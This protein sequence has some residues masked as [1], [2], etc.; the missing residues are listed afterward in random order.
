[1]QT[2]TSH[3][4]NTF[5]NYMSY[6]L[7]PNNYLY[8]LSTHSSHSLY[9][10]VYHQHRSAALPPIHDTLNPS[11]HSHTSLL[12]YLSNNNTY[13]NLN[14]TSFNS[15]FNTVISRFEVLSEIH[16]LMIIFLQVQEFNA[17]DNLKNSIIYTNFF[18]II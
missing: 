7:P 5:C 12:Y 11:S 2:Q 18:L 13:G 14:L 17:W 6:S 8:T 4:L 9:L 16:Q 1:M 10:A 3:L 15:A